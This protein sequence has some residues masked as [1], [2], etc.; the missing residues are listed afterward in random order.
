MELAITKLASGIL[1]PEEIVKSRSARYPMLV[2]ALS[3]ETENLVPK[4]Q[5]YY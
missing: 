1:T 5:F 2:Q 4:G 3:R